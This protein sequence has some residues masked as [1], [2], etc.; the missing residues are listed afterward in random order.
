MLG[1]RD[2]G[3]RG[4]VEYALHELIGF[5]H[6]YD[7]RAPWKGLPYEITGLKVGIVGLGVSGGMVA[8]ALQFMGRGSATTAA[9]ASRSTRS[10]ESPISRFWSFCVKT[11]WC[12]PA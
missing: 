9:A 6:G 2:Y 3:D 5:L 7:G 10:A 8:A 1:I 12:S 11:R 4:V